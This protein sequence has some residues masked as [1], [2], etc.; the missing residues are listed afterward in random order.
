MHGFCSTLIAEFYHYYSFKSSSFQL[1]LFLF[2]TYSKRH[3][4]CGKFECGGGMPVRYIDRLTILLLL[5]EE[6]R[7]KVCSN[8]WQYQTR[9]YY[10]EQ[11]AL[12]VF[13]QISVVHVALTFGAPLIVLYKQRDLKLCEEYQE[14][15]HNIRYVCLRMH[16]YPEKNL[17]PCVGQTYIYLPIATDDHAVDRIS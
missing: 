13:N 14:A 2:W 1:T 11:K 15:M 9:W 8:A 7:T 4:T 12:M 16:S 6:Q 10:N 3:K 17:D 5:I